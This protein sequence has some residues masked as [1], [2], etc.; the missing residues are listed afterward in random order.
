MF[1]RIAFLIFVACIMFPMVSADDNGIKSL[2]ETSKTFA[3]IARSASP[4]VVYIQAEGQSSRP[5]PP[6]F[7]F[8]Y[9]RQRPFDDDFLEH[10]FGDKFKWFSMPKAPGQRYR[11]VSQG[12][13]FIFSTKKNLF[14]NKSY[15]ITNSHVVSNS[16]SIRVKLIDGQEYSAKIKGMDSLSDLAVLE[17]DVG[18]LPTLPLGD[19][20]KLEV[21][22]WVVAIGNPFGLSHSLTVGVVSA[23]G[24][25]SLGINDYE[26]FIQTD[27]AIN[28]GNSG[29]PLIN[30]AG[31]VVGINTAIF[32]RSGA[33]NG[34]GFSIPI[35]LAKS[36]ADQLLANGSI[37]RGYLGILI[38][39]LTPQLA[40]S[41]G[42]E[43]KKGILVSQINEDSPAAQSDLKQGDVIIAYAGKP[44]LR[45]AEF[46]NRVALSPPGSAQKITV[47]RDG[48][49][50]N[51]SVVIGKR[52]PQ[53][54]G[55]SSIEYTEEKLGLTVNNLTEELARKYAVKLGRGILVTKVRA[56]SISA[57]ANIQPGNIILQVNR[58]PV[59]SVIDFQRTI[60]KAKSD[61][62]VLLLLQDGDAQR[63][64]VL[65]W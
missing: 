40:E 44:V 47:I 14:S 51:I 38:Q 50:K 52:T 4:S 45:L 18:D 26:D 6:G 55:V 12:S 19:S 15:I 13:G 8:P 17:I 33:F 48:K 9:E 53:N 39:E 22:E 28:P 16:E 20:S 46:R 3:T 57:L 56:G 1:M 5:S 36:I 58:K 65:N 10:F 32:T 31:E 59:N 35:N 62:K 43:E 60:R 24:R 37:T 64:A 63:Y 23:K 25:S 29:G 54:T 2:K 34:I 27:A 42:I 21:G 7:I 11:G 49:Q 41:F 30:L 61:K